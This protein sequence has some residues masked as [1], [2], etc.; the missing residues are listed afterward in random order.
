VIDWVSNLDKME[1]MVISSDMSLTV[2]NDG[3]VTD[4]RG[5]VHEPTNLVYDSKHG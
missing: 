1:Y 5:L 2:G 3:H 4:V